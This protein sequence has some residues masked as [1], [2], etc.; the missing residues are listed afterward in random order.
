MT[1]AHQRFQQRTGEQKWPVLPASRNHNIA[2][3]NKATE[4]QQTNMIAPSTTLT[5][6][7][8]A[9]TGHA[10]DYWQFNTQGELV[11]VHRQYRKTLFTP[12]RT[13]CRVPEEQPEDNRKTTIRFKDGATNTFEDKYQTV[14]IQTK[15]SRRC[16]KEKQHSGSRKAHTCQKQQQFATNTQTAKER[17]TEGHT[18]SDSLQP[19]NEIERENNTTKPHTTKG[20]AGQG[21]PH[22]SEV[23]P[24]GLLVQRRPILEESTC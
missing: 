10:G 9:D 12:S 7:G 14:E 5:R 15:H 1:T 23:N 16:G 2:K 18:T 20:A 22:A 3:R 24:E 4:Q 17:A 13:Q 6:Q 21:I 8:P 19:T 11:R